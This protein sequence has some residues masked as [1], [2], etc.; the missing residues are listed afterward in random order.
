MEISTPYSNCI[1]K[2]AYEIEHL[3]IKEKMDFFMSNTLSN[4]SQQKYKFPTETFN[5]YIPKC[6]SFSKILPHVQDIKT[7]HRYLHE[8][9]FITLPPVCEDMFHLAKGCC[10][11]KGVF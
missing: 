3:Q 7:H 10:K 1:Q 11:K 2:I 5:L 9:I 4:L 8:E 6:P